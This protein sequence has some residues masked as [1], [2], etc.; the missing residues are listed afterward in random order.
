MPH[1]TFHDPRG[2]EWEAWEVHPA[3]VEHRLAAERRKA[4]RDKLDRRRRKESRIV[5]DP[6][7]TKGWLAFQT[8]D[9]RR[10]I[11]PIP[12]GWERLTDT[13]LA[14]LAERAESLGRPRRLLE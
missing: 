14:R 11:A 6:E 7:L 13:E 5:V 4:A 12:D 8:R 9:E 3:A 10:R 1:R 2:R